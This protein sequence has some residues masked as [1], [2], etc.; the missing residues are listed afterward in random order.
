DRTP[1]C[2]CKRAGIGYAAG[3][4]GSHETAATA[5]DRAVVGVAGVWPVSCRRRRLSQRLLGVRGDHPSLQEVRR[6]SPLL[7]AA[8]AR[9]ARPAARRILASPS[10][11][12]LM[13][14]PAKS[15]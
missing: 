5:G 4:E 13:S 12:T 9:R 14:V 7:A 8:P 11:L 6:K 15:P 1:P 2:S 3:L 10:C